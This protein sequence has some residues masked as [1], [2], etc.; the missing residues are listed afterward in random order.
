METMDHI[1]SG[2]ILILQDR[3]S[4][5]LTKEEVKGIIISNIDKIVDEVIEEVKE[6]K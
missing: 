3:P 2:L 6:C 1:I 4:Y 5:V